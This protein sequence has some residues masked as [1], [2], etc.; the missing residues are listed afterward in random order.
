VI[1]LTVIGGLAFRLALVL[2]DPGN[3]RAAYFLTPGR[4]DGLM[5]GA[6]LAVVA[7]MPGG[8]TRLESL[9]P[10]VL[11]AGVVTLGLLATLRGSL[12]PADPV[13]AVAAFPVVAL[14]FGALL[15]MALTAPPAGRLARVLRRDGLRKWGTYSYGIYVIHLPLLGAIEYKTKFYQHGVALLGGSR[16]PSVL[17]LAAV[18]AS[19]SY[20]IGWLSYHL[21]EKRFLEL[22]R[23]FARPSV[24]RASVPL[25]TKLAPGLETP[26]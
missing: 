19:M 2:H 21:Y 5:T 17:L 14:V 15:V 11:G 25:G 20:A 9:A 16:L 6:A 13:L 26:G 3:A 22:K 1:G 18:A 7:R 12:N 4:L 24:A 8:L 10:R 23:Y